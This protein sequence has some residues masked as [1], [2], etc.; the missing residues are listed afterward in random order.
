ME[1]TDLE[2]RQKHRLQTSAMAAEHK[3]DADLANAAA[4][5]ENFKIKLAE[6]REAFVLLEKTA[7]ERFS[8]LRQI[9]PVA[10]SAP[11]MA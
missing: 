10:L 6:S 7:R 5:L 2:G 9:P 4:T 11:A 3:R 1:G 8:R